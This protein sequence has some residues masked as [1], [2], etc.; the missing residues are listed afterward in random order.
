MYIY[1]QYIYKYTYYTIPNIYID[2]CVVRLCRPQRNSMTQGHTIFLP[3]GSRQGQVE[4]RSNDLQ[5]AIWSPSGSNCPD[6]FALHMFHQDSIRIIGSPFVRLYWY[7][8]FC[9]L[10]FFLQSVSAQLCFEERLCCLPAI[11][12]ASL[13]EGSDR[14]A[15]SRGSSTG[16][17]F[18]GGC[19]QVPCLGKKREKPKDPTACLSYL[20]NGWIMSYESWHS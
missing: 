12:W 9:F 20:T 15:D 19:F 1:I 3:E 14:A 10:F 4:F 17:F 5:P 11:A 16:A 13:T 8:L 2:V 18:D 6:Y 7:L